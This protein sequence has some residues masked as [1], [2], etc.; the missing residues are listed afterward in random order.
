VRPAIAQKGVI[1]KMV[2]YDVDTD[3]RLYR[4]FALVLIS[5]FVAAALPKADFDEQLVNDFVNGIPLVGP[6]VAPYVQP[7]IAPFGDLA[8]LAT[9]YLKPFVIFGV[10]LTLFD[11]VLWRVPMVGRML[12]GIPYLGG[13]W[14]GTLWRSDG[15]ASEPVK[16]YIRQTWRQIQFAVE[17]PPVTERQSTQGNAL[18]VGMFVENPQDIHV[19]YIYEVRPMTLRYP[20]N[21]YTQASE[22]TAVLRFR[23][24]SGT[25]ILRGTYYSDRRR[26]GDLELNRWSFRKEI[27]EAIRRRFGH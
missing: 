27:R 21:P 24:E 18:T 8:N 25:Q 2:L 15:S 13:T 7:Y 10:F 14:E 17:G 19:R 22:G 12:S 1:E 6:Y 11:R 26:S 3:P 23:R 4:Y 20:D 16:C 9:P 5:I